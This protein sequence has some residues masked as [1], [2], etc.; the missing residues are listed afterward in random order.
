MHF[1]SI[2][3]VFGLLLMVTGSTMLFPAL[4]SLYYGE[5]DLIPLVVSA[6]VTFF[7][8]L[9]AWWL[10]RKNY[11]LNMKDG[12]IVAVFG[13]FIVS[14]FSALPFMLHGSIPS[15]TDAYFEMISG[16]TTTGATVLTDIE[17]VPHGLLFW[18][19]ETHLLGGMGFLTLTV[20]L[21]PQGM[22]GLRLF[23]AESS[24]G[25]VITKEKFKPR[26]RDT[27][28]SLWWIYLC[29]NFLQAG[30][31]WAGDMSIFDALCTA[32]G[33]ISTSG[34]SP[35]NLSIG[36]YNS[37]YFD[38]VT[39]LFMFLGGTTFLLFFLLLQGEWKAVYRNTEFKWYVV[40][41]LFFSVMVS[42]I[43]LKNGTYNTIADAFRFGTFQVM[44]LL[45]TTG[46]TTTNYELWPQA[47][48]MFLFAVCFVGACAGSTTSGIKVVHYVII[49]KYMYNSIRKIF[50]QPRS[51]ITIRLNQKAVDSSVVDLALC[52]FIVNIFMVLGGGC[53]MSLLEELD[54]ISAMSAV[55]S[56]LMNI[57]PGFGA[58][59]PSENFAFLSDASKWFLSWNMLVGR[60]EMFSAL[61]IFYPS[62]WKK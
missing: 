60:L 3:H 28:I 25:Q 62:F 46:F 49:C 36:H 39:I 11:E 20:I 45:T 50:F 34:Y 8:G 61:V 37:A 32:F 31:L 2:I 48:Q 57:G 35:K 16:Y 23:R 52:Y 17:C 56:A 38:W 7:L 29:L 22:G 42:L 41:V 54:Y 6:A 12:I 55:I 33:T 14:A 4:C 5:G 21:L 43:L 10:C 13:W 9:P 30:L 18:R 53:L 1:A 47:A 58:V 24:P 44:S 51:V 59:G 15:F 40:L 19:S 26:N 27:M